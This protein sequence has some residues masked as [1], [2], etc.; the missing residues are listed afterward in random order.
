MVEEMQ[1][2]RYLLGGNFGLLD[3]T[4]GWGGKATLSDH[5]QGEAAPTR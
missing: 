3:M 1:G 2:Q 5:E 4:G